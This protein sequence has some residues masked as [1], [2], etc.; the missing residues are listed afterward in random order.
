MDSFLFLLCFTQPRTPTYD[1]RP[2]F[3]CLM[4]TLELVES[5]AKKICHWGE[6]D[7]V[8][9]K[10]GAPLEEGAEMYKELQ[11]KHYRNN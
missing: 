6:D 11:N 9:M 5:E 8:A 7:S 2:D 10:L 3:P 4:T 1:D